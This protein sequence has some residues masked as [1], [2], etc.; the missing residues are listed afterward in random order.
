M[1]APY[2]ERLEDEA[3]LDL[4]VDSLESYPAWLEQIRALSGLE[5]PLNLSGI[6]E[7]AFD[8]TRFEALRSRGAELRG[9]GV[10]C[11][12]LDRAGLLEIEPAVGRHAKGGLLLEGEGC[13]DNRRLG[14]SLTAACEAAGVTIAGHIRRIERRM[15]RTAGARGPRRARLYACL[16]RGR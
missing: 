2:T 15:R 8:E 1:L 5:V 4:C 16:R 9:R 11:R 12:L 13:V 14:R 6:L 10:S 7:T 3:L